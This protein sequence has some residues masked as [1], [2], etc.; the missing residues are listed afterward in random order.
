MYTFN[1][2]INFANYKHFIVYKDGYKIL[3]EYCI[4]L[5]GFFLSKQHKSSQ[6]VENNN[7]VEFSSRSLLMKTNLLFMRLKTQILFLTGDT[8]LLL[9]KQQVST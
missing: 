1:V 6:F 3:Y 7:T 2:P 4:F 9:V 8:I 5:D